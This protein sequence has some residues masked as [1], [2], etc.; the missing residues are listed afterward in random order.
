VRRPVLP[1]SRAVKVR[2]EVSFETLTRDVPKDLVD[3]ISIYGKL[4][5][6]R[7]GGLAKLSKGQTDKDSVQ[8]PRK[9]FFYRRE[10]PA[11][12]YMST[13]EWSGEVSS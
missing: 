3:L 13:N 12:V 9:D 2:K 11:L 6:L 1:Q 5:E 10:P 4:V 8:I 7:R